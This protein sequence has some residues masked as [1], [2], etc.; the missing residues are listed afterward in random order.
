EREAGSV[1]LVWNAAPKAAY[2]EVERMRE[3]QGGGFE[4]VAMGVGRL[5]WED[6]G[7][8]GGETYVYRV[9]AWNYGGYSD[10]TEELSVTVPTLGM[11]V[12]VPDAG[13]RLWLRGD[14]GLTDG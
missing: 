4:V 10:Y 11:E 6:T 3:G 12:P 5:G 8:S 7:A 13:L 1:N 9:R 14:L 2:Y